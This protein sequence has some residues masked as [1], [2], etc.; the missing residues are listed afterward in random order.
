MWRRLSWLMRGGAR[1]CKARPPVFSPTGPALWDKPANRRHAPHPAPRWHCP[2]AVPG[3]AATAPLLRGKIRQN[4]GGGQAH[5]AWMWKSRWRFR[6]LRSETIEPYQSTIRIA[7]KL[8]PRRTHEIHEAGDWNRHDHGRCRL[9]PPLGAVACWFLT[10]TGLRRWNSIGTGRPERFYDCMWNTGSPR[11]GFWLGIAVMLLAV[12]PAGAAIKRVFALTAPASVV[13]NSRIV[14]SVVMSTDAGAGERIAFFQAEYSI[15]GG[16]T[17]TVCWM[18]DELGATATRELVFSAGSAGSRALVRARW[19][20]TAAWPGR[21]IAR[22]VRSGG[23]TPGRNGGS[24]RRNR[25][26]RR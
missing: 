3:S 20:F 12:G 19:L 15:D 16:R 24:R 2:A 6:L 4:P 8:K 18:E 7:K 17:W 10:V 22:A 13:A 1:C 26:S 5:Q 25:P 14:V 11:C 23:S 21:S 9:R